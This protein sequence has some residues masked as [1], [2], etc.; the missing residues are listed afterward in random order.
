MVNKRK[1]M[2]S[3]KIKPIYRRLRMGKKAHYTVWYFYE[4][5][6]RT[7]LSKIRTVTYE[8]DWEDLINKLKQ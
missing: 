3:K 8:S 1:A 7:G 6:K 4:I 2:I 5:I